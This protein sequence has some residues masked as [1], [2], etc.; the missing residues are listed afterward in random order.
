MS[1]TDLLQ[2][3][4]A[5]LPEPIAAE[6]LDFLEFVTAKRQVDSKQD[7]EKIQD[8][9]GSF[10]GKISSSVEFAFQKSDE[11]HLEE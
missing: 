1:K 11:I 5:T 10:K 2:A 4:V 3:K 6:V 8:P 7:R 9:R